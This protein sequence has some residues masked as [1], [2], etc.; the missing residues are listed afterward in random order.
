[1]M[2]IIFLCFLASFLP[3]T[4]VNIADEQNR[5]PWLN[6]V[7]SVLAWASSVV[8][9][10]VYAASNR[11]Y[12]VAYYKLFARLKFWGAPL[13]PIISKSYQP[14]RDSAAVAA[15]AATA[16][17]GGNRT[18]RFGGASALAIGVNNRLIGD[19]NNVNSSAKGGVQQQQQQK[20]LPQT[21]QAS[22]LSTMGE[23]LLM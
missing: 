12:R 19:A 17:A 7:A 16:A 20:E 9:P 15:A 22:D 21:M 4:L 11:T 5:Y 8:N 18:N 2:L 13:A 1:M 10:F 6:I 14:S 3:L 23:N